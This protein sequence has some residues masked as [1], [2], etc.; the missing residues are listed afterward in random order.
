[1][2]SN[3]SHSLRSFFVVMSVAAFVL[4]WVWEMAQMRVYIEMAQVPWWDTV[5]PCT[6]A[7]LGDVVITFC[8]YG[9]G[10]LASGQIG[11][12]T[13]GRWNVYAAATVLGSAC[14]VGIEWKAQLSG[15]W[16]YTERM[17]VIPGIAVG[18]WP[19]LQLTLLIPAALCIAVWW[20]RRGQKCT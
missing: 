14:A 12:G 3:T 11:W 18:L 8:V 2:A 10:A 15:T 19:L 13:T 7:T 4:N 1:M 17:L 16:S 5:L 20:S 6:V 9:V